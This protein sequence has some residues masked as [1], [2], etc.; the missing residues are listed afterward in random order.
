[1]PPRP[2]IRDRHVV[3]AAP[4]PAPVALMAELP[5]PTD[6]ATQIAAARELV[7]DC[8]TGAD[9]RAL[10][11]VG[12]CS[13]HDPAAAL[14]YA[15]RLAALQREVADALVLVMRVYFEKP[16]TTIG[17]KGLVTDPLLNGE[18]DIALGLRRARE[19]LLGVADRGLPAATE[20]LDPIVPQYLA[21]LVT[22]A[23]IGARTTESQTHRE[24]ASGLSM[25]VGFK[26]GTEGELQT[27]LDAMVSAAAP[28]RFLGVDPDGRVAM[29]ATTGNPDRHL[30][31]RG[32]RNGPNY[33]A[34]QVSA[35]V[36]AC[37]AAGLPNRILVDCSHA[38]SGKDPMR[39]P[40]VL[41]DLLAQEADGERHLLGWMLESHLLPGRQA[42]GGDP[43]AL[44]YGVSITDGCLGWEQT[45]DLLRGAAAVRRR[46]LA[47]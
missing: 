26:N 10:V 45:A 44:R 28:H 21:D 18:G 37:T 8:I 41:A 17:W 3:T 23:A 24:L 47:A 36:A 27:A 33:R 6:A 12:P 9:R 39:Q 20:F 13:I 2:P 4:L 5:V 19:V 38:N 42:L 31:L 7:R 15:D 11:I 43:S 32:G 35:A 46:V 25:P 34:P 1:M 22:W 16:R 14:E 29:I 40:E 30:V